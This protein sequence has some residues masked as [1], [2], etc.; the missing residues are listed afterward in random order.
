[1]LRAQWPSE[2]ARKYEMKCNRSQESP[3]TIRVRLLVLVAQ[4]VREQDLVIGMTTLLQALAA[5]A[6]N[7]GVARD[8]V[9][10]DA[11]KCLDWH[12]SLMVLNCFEKRLNAK[13]GFTG[14]V[15]DW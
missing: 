12:S 5:M 13:E 3:D 1:M 9:P 8:G 6:C 14:A 10:A 4:G 15:D 7:K 2:F 11:L